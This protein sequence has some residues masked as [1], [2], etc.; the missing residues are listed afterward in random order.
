MDKCC[1]VNVGTGARF[2]RGTTRLLKSVRS[3]GFPVLTWTNGYPPGSPTHQE[4]PY[5]FKC[6]AMKAA[7]DAGYRYV[8]WWDSAIVA[9]KSPQPFFDA[10]KRDGYYFRE[11]GWNCGQWM[12]DRSLEI[13]GLSRDEALKMPDFVGA[14]IG[15]DFEHS[16]AV[17]WFEEWFKHAMTGA[18]QGPTT[19]V[20]N[21]CSCDP[22]CLGHRHDQVVGSV[23]FNR[24]GLKFNQDDLFS[25][26]PN[27][28]PNCEEK[29][30][31]SIVGVRL[32]CI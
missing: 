4:Q 2:V 26:V 27:S 15:V 14:C 28:W 31:P 8:L 18:F 20:G 21:C 30:R 24:L 9:V 10:I 17:T 13:M 5:A 16:Q 7:R 3:Y 22:R 25:Y 11:N 1:I 32:R 23:I 29:L 6:Y 19:N 12:T